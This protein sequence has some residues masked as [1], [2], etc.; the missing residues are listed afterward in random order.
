MKLKKIPLL[1]PVAL[2]IVGISSSCVKE[3]LDA[4]KNGFDTE[5]Q[6]NPR[7][8]VP[9]AKANL[10]LPDLIPENETVDQFLEINDS[11]YFELYYQQELYSLSADEQVEVPNQLFEQT[12]TLGETE[13]ANFNFALNIAVDRDYEY[14]FAA[15]AGMHIDY[16]TFSGGQLRVE[17]ESQWAADIIIQLK[18]PGFVKDNDTL[19]LDFGN[20]SEPPY[21]DQ[22]FDLEGYKIDLTN[23]ETTF[24]KLIMD[25]AL[26]LSQ[27]AGEI[28]ELTDEISVTVTLTDIAFQSV[29][30]YFG[31]RTQEIQENSF[32]F[33]FTQNIFEGEIHLEDPQFRVFYTNSFGLPVQFEFLSLFAID[34]DNMQVDINLPPSFDPVQLNTPIALGDSIADTLALTGQ[35]SNLFDVI[36]NFPQSITFGGAVDLNKDVDSLAYAENF[37]PGDGSFSIATEFRLPLSANFRFAI[38]RPIAYTIGEI[39]QIDNVVELAVKLG[40]DNTFPIDIGVQVYFVDSVS[41]TRLDSMFSVL[42]PGQEMEFINGSVDGTPVH[43]DID[44]V[45]AQEKVEKIKPANQIIFKAVIESAEF[46]T[47]EYIQITDQYSVGFDMGFDLE[48]S[49]DPTELGGG[50]DEE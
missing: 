41:G 5:A 30:G 50:S 10:S 36:L 28:S 1:L 21:V 42:D 12:L 11:G 2:I 26:Q 34:N 6:L 7:Y 22:T 3:Y 25:Y 9:V 40:L 43:S 19:S 47:G 29:E 46:E 17:M 16:L 4:Y 18:L 14:D 31:T 15:P 48:L 38:E 24:N 39:P 20:I 23:G 8:S 32:E 49:V 45:F 35:N 37:L 27:E 44:L 13:L 33:G